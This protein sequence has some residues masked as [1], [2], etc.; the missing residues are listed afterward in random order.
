MILRRGKALLTP[1]FPNPEF[2]IN[3]CGAISGS[4]TEKTTMT[5]PEIQ[6]LACRITNYIGYLDAAYSEG[7]IEEAY[8]RVGDNRYGVIVYSEKDRKEA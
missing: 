4:M 2:D 8:M 3:L 7:F 1:H 6:E 5:T